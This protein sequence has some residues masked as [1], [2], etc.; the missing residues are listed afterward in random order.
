MS[1]LLKE[2][3]KII[4]AEKVSES[5]SSNQ[6]GQAIGNEITA[7]GGDVSHVTCKGAGS[8]EGG[9][10]RIFLNDLKEKSPADLMRLAKQSV[11][12]AFGSRATVKNIGPVH[13]GRFDTYEVKS[14]GNVYNIVFSGG[15]TTGQRGGGYEYEGDVK[16]LL[17]S[18]G[19]KVE[20][21]GADTTLSD[22]FL[23]TSSGKDVG[24]EVKGAG[25]KFGQPTLQYSYSSAEFMAPAASRS[26]QNA[27]LVVDI[28]NASQDVDLKKWMNSI[29]KSWD[30]LHPED[31]MKVLGTQI[32]PKDWES[33][34]RSGIGQSGPNIS[35][36]LDQ[37]VT[38]Y[39]KKKAHYIQIQ[40]KGLYAF[41]DILKLGVTTFVDAA[42]SL[43][44]FIKPEI[45]KSGG[46]K[47]LR[48]S[49]SL[50]YRTL[51]GSNMDLA[52]P[53]DAQKF[54]SALKKR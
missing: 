9:H 35:M 13:S 30:K 33:M 8:K 26:S 47:V 49:I 18:A 34:M 45:L 11:E 52:N 20:D 29:K 40:G 5:L 36:D 41:N 15:L 43:D 2:Y 14:G 27:L 37:I 32:Q 22:V 51:A 54:A 46:N 28:L 17:S 38:Y 6:V 24:I 3:V 44:A 4:L 48:A 25:A 42:A 16:R 31:K 10:C 23:K 12:K 39:K 1:E 21:V 53:E 7:L 19:A 50:N